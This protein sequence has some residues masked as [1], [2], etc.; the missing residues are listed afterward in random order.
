MKHILILSIFSFLLFSC[1]KIDE[2]TKFDLNYTHKVTIPSSLAV[3]TPFDIPTPEV[4]T[5]SSSTFSNNNTKADLVESIVLSN[6]KLELTSPTTSDL[7]FLNEIFIY[8]KADG[9]GEK[10]IATKTNIPN[11]VGQTLT[12]NVSGTELKD[13]LLKD[14]FSLRVKVKTDKLISKD[15]KIDVKT[16]F[17]VDA[18]V[19]GI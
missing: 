19:L 9:L 8:I 15:H 12:M 10:Q 6:M 18:K 4:E 13:Y 7:S 16:T 14:K 3:N 1:K 2:F 11:D 5:N 17:R